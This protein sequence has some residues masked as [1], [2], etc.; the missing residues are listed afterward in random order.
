[1]ASCNNCGGSGTVMCDHC[2]GTGEVRNSSYIIGLSEI[3]NLANDYERCSY[4]HGRGEKTCWR[5]DGS[6]EISDD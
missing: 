2:D 3:T 6:G 5:C 1:M 4:C